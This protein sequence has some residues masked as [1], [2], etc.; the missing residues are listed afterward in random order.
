MKKSSYIEFLRFFAALCVFMLHTQELLTGIDKH[1]AYV[2]AVMVEF[3]FMLS[4]FL[5][6]RHIIEKPDENE[7]VFVYT[8]NKAKS[9]FLPVFK[10][11]LFIS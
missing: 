4:G 2:L 1:C 6:M 7:D 8:F 10:C 3:F 11:T 9:V 5:M